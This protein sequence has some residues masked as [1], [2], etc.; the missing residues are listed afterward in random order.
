[1]RIE[2]YSDKYVDD[3]TQI[4]KNFHEEAI[5]DYACTLDPDAVLQTIRTA[6]KQNVFL[7]VDPNGKAQGIL[8]GNRYKLPTGG[9]AFQEVIW[10]VN[11]TYRTSGISLLRYVEKHLKSIGVSIMIMVALEN[12]KTDKLHR[13]YERLGYR[14][15]ETHFVR[16]L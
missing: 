13:F 2:T 15:M 12:S 6:D 3:I 11:T 1:M 10:Y 8:Y 9:E 16:T 7:L 4:I 5:K 14:P